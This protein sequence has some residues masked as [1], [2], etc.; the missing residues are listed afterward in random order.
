[1]RLTPP[2]LARPAIACA[3]LLLAGCAPRPVEDMPPAEPAA[4]TDTATATAAYVVDEPPVGAATAADAPP[5][6]TP[7]PTEHE[8]DFAAIYGGDVYA[9]A[10][11]PTLPSPA[12]LP[13]SYDPWEPFN[14]QMHAVNT[15]IDTRIARP[16]ANAYMEVV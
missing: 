10:A 12:E 2:V 4:M 15:V 3:L 5:E 13:E 9:P 14:R 16:L 11:D 7:A 8:L 1:M 6:P